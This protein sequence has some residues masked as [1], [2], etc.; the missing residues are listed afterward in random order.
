MQFKQQYYKREIELMKQLSEILNLID[1]V[2]VNG[3]TQNYSVDNISFDSHSVNDNSVFIAIKGF[4]VNGHDFIEDVISKGVKVIV[5]EEDNLPDQLYVVNNCVKIKVKCSRRAL[6]QISNAYYDFPSTK[7]KLIGITGTKGKTTTTFFIKNILEKAGHKVG[8][9]GTNENYVGD[10]KYSTKL[11][12]PESNTLN[13]LLSEM[14]AEGCEYCVMEVS[15]HSLELQRVYGLDFNIA[16]FTN[17]TSDHMDF[18]ENFE[19]YR[20]AKKILFDNL[21]T[22]AHAVFN[23]DDE[24]TPYMSNNSE[25]MISCYGK[26]LKSNYK[27][28]NL[29]YNLDGTKF[30]IRMNGSHFEINIKLIG[31]FNAY[32]AAAAFTVCHLFGIDIEKIV[33]GLNTTKQIPGRFEVISYKSKKVIIDYS[34]TSGSL[35]EALVAIRN[36]VKDENPVHTVFGCGGDR[37]KSKR[38]EMG[39]IAEE[40]SDKIYVTSDNPR[41]EDPFEIIEDIKEGLTKK[42]YQ[43]IEN[44]EEAIRTAIKSSEEDAVILI[45]GKGHE[46]YQEINGVRSYFS[47]KDTAIKYLES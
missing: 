3:S 28:E 38:P 8:L 25:A 39:R 20:D 27:I 6:A 12:T 7:I 35:K 45:A 40:Y 46:N 2:S 4:K 34:H 42:D 32:N 13:A 47:D 41:T 36:I 18:H 22:E 10:K 19:N 26:G 37:D 30:S 11:T 1:A 9:I 44:R 16:V 14:V 17:I 31:G 29:S 21:K 43:E 33:E 23:C 24:N 15:S 5:V